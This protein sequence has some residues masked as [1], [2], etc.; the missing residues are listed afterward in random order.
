MRVRSNAI[1][2][3]KVCSEIGGDL[4]RDLAGRPLPGSADF[5]VIPSIVC[6]DQL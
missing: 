6:N 2:I 5:L 4:C 1:A 3:F